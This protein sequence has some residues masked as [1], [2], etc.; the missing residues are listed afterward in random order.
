VALDPENN[1]DVPGIS[2]TFN[3]GTYSTTFTYTYIGIFNAGT[4][5]NVVASAEGYETDTKDV[6]VSDALDTTWQQITFLLSKTLV[7]KKAD[8]HQLH[9]VR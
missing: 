4:N 3:G 6:V 5:L 1:Y 7:Y 8:S 9:A 2:F